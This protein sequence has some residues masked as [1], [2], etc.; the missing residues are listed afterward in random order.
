MLDLHVSFARLDLSNDLL[1][2]MH[3]EIKQVINRELRHNE[4]KI[5]QQANN[6][7]QKA[8]SSRDVR[9]PLLGY[10]GLP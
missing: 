10:F 3:R 8:M 9:I 6:A 5:R 7:L 2:T 1:E 4:G